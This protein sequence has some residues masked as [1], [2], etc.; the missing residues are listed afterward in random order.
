MQGF[1]MW[2]VQQKALD[3]LVLALVD[4]HRPDDALLVER[5]EENRP[6]SPKP[7][8][9]GAERASAQ[10]SLHS[11]APHSTRGYAMD[12]PLRGFAARVPEPR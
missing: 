3:A 2:N 12:H 7:H 1:L 8:R 11:A 5:A 10:D 9:W 6:S 4:E